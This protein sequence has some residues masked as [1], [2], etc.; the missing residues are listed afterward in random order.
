ME[1]QNFGNILDKFKQGTNSMEAVYNELAYLTSN[2]DKKI[3]KLQKELEE[4]KGRANNE[5]F[6]RHEA[7]K[8]LED[9]RKIHEADFE[10]L[11]DEILEEPKKHFKNEL[12]TSIKKFTLISSVVAI[13]AIVAIS[14][15]SQTI[16]NTPSA[17]TSS[18]EIEKLDKKLNL[19]NTKL[20]ELKIE[21]KQLKELLEKKAIKISNIEE[22]KEIPKEQKEKLNKEEEII[23][24]NPVKEEKNLANNNSINIETQDEFLD[25]VMLQINEYHKKFKLT[26]KHD[27]RI[28]YKMFLLDL[29]PFKHDLIIDELKLFAKEGTYVPKKEDLLIWD[30]QMLLIYNKMLEAIKD[31]PDS[32]I[33]SEMRSFDKYK[34]NDA[35]NY[36]GWEYVG[37]KDLSLKESI[38]KEIDN[39]TS[40]MM[41]NKS[42]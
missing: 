12:D 10:R 24:V 39:L 27:T 14:F 9:L 37:Q 34:F 3:E 26:T 42:K 29:S 7:E 13:V 18:I 21:N 20:N 35:T 22:K 38:K 1:N 31:I 33:T 17:K 40:Q 15:Y 6:V 25:K 23:I 11:L 4:E 41:I 19:I 36:L 32:K 28:L 30:K 5:E 2:Y 8:N 16:S